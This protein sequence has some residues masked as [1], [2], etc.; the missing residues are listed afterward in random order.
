MVTQTV[1]ITQQLGQGGVFSG[2]PL[3]FGGW[4]VGVGSLPQTV[5]L[6]SP[7]NTYLLNRGVT[8]QNAADFAVDCDTVIGQCAVRFKPSA[9]GPRTAT[10]QTQYGNIALSGVG[11]PAGPS[12]AVTPTNAAYPV[13]V[14]SSTAVGFLVVNNGT[15]PVSPVIT[16]LPPTD[17]SVFNITYNA[18]AACPSTLAVQDSCMAYVIFKPT[19][20]GE[21]PASLQVKD[22][23]SGF[24]TVK[25]YTESGTASASGSLGLYP[26]DLGI[27]ALNGVGGNSIVL[28]NG[29]DTFTVGPATGGNA[30]SEF[31]AFLPT[32]CGA[33]PTQGGCYLRVS[34]T[35]TALGLRTSS[36][37]IT[38]ETTGKSGTLWVQGTGGQAILSMSP[39][40]VS[41]APTETGTSSAEQVV[42]I[43]NY[44]NAAANLTRTFG[45]EMRARLP[46]MVVPAFPLL[47]QA[48][49]VL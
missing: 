41:F 20:V 29:V 4:G 34:L 16:L 14:G 33:G 49:A 46:S 8:G 47:V 39:N 17:T 18:G 42:T 25:S 9:L 22:T 6:T 48:R 28:D 31:S 35:P 45:S 37:V 30:N 43:R 2:K 40:S 11:Q 32:S 12:I 38:D 26:L 36:F 21:Y 5:T 7:Q 13:Q 10:L 24:T 19:Q 3:D 23:I 15:V 1:G 44:G 27:V